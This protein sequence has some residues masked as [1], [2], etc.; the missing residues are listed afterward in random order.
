VAQDSLK[1]QNRAREQ[2]AGK[3]VPVE[4]PDLSVPN[5][6]SNQANHSKGKSIFFSRQIK[7]MP[8]TVKCKCTKQQFKECEQTFFL[9]SKP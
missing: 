4:L 5:R 3:Q 9:F 1:P 6:V 2:H 8:V 7:R